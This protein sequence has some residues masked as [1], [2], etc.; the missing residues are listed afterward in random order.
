MGWNNRRQ[1]NWALFIGH[2]NGPAYLNLL[3]NNPIPELVRLF[4]N[5]IEQSGMLQNVLRSFKD[6]MACCIEV[7][8]QHFEHLL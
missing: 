5:P 8:G 7:N 4:A 1:S 3:E 2:L 6:R